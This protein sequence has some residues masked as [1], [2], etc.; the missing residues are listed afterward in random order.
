MTIE[1]NK[2]YQGNTLDVLKTWPDEFV[3]C[4]VTSPPYWNLRDYGIDGQIGLEPYPE[5]YVM[6][7]VEVFSE[8]KRVLRNDG[9]LWLNIGDSYAGGGRGFGYGGKQDTNKGCDGMPKSI[10]PQGLKPKDLCEI[11]SD[12]VRALRHDGW[13]LRSR[14]PWIKRT[15]MP[16]SAKDRPTNAIEYVFLLSKSEKYFYDYEAVKSPSSEDTHARYSRSRGNDHKWIDTEY[17]RTFIKK[18]NENRPG[19]NPKAKAVSGWDNGPGNHRG[20]T[21]RYPNRGPKDIARDEQG[22][23]PSDRMGRGPGWRNKQNESFSAAVKDVVD[24]RHRRNSD[25]FFESWQG[26]LSAEEGDPLAFV[27]NPYPF[28]EA[29]FATFPPRLVEPCIL[30]GSRTGDIVLDPFSGSGT[31][32]SVAKRLDRQYLGIEL[33]PAYVEMSER[34]ILKECGGL[35]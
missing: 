30:A 27:V 12:V 28:K 26:L 31:T 11:P 32:C 16:E 2:I 10:V 34:R 21:G 35:F 22:L 4:C 19:V 14:I 33:N 13:Y 23:K 7:M 25:W 18:H 29:H 6:K 1:L 15:A 8:V 9:T 24:M 20:L 17:T 3:Q 5:E